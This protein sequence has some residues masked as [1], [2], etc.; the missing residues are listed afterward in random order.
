[1]MAGDEY[2]IREQVFDL[3][4][5]GDHSMTNEL[6]K[7]IEVINDQGIIPVLEGVCQEVIP[8]QS[9]YE[10]DVLELDIGICH[11]ENLEDELPDKIRDAF[12]ESLTNIISR[13][14]QDDGFGASEGNIFPVNRHSELLFQFLEN[15]RFPWWYKDEGIDIDWRNVIVLAR[16]EDET[17]LIERV[18]SL[19]GKKIV[20]NR[21]IWQLPGEAVFELMT[22]LKMDV[23]TVRIIA[24]LLDSFEKMEFTAGLKNRFWDEILKW[25][26]ESR[27]YDILESSILPQLA[28]KVNISPLILAKKLLKISKKVTHQRSSDTHEFKGWLKAEI[29]NLDTQGK[30]ERRIRKKLKKVIRSLEAVSLDHDKLT[31]P[32]FDANISEYL[33]NQMLRFRIFSSLDDKSIE[34]ILGSFSREVTHLPALLKWFST[35]WSTLVKDHKASFHTFRTFLLEEFWGNRSFMEREELTTTNRR[36]ARAILTFFSTQS[37]PIKALAIATRQSIEKGP[38]SKGIGVL[39]ALNNLLD[40][41]ISDQSSGSKPVIASWKDLISKLQNGD[42]HDLP[43]WSL[44]HQIQDP[45]V[46]DLASIGEIPRPQGSEPYDQLGVLLREQLKSKAALRSVVSNLPDPVLHSLVR[47]ISPAIKPKDADQWI[48]FSG[49]FHLHETQ[50]IPGYKLRNDYWFHLFSIL[51]NQPEIQADELHGILLKRLSDF[52]GLKAEVIYSEI[53]ALARKADLDHLDIVKWVKAHVPSRTQLETDNTRKWI[54]KLLRPFGKESMYKESGSAPEQTDASPNKDLPPGHGETQET[55][56]Q[57]TGNEDQKERGI[58]SYYNGPIKEDQKIVENE[59]LVE[60]ESKMTQESS[61]LDKEDA[62]D[63]DSQQMLEESSSMDIS[64]ALLSHIDEEEWIPDVEIFIQNAGMVIIGPFLPN[65]FKT[66]GLLDEHQNFVSETSIYQAIHLLQGTVTR[67]FNSPEHLLTLNKIICGLDPLLP[68]PRSVD[69][70]DAMIR[71]T[72]E[73]LKAV[74]HHWTAL[75][76]T[77]VDGLRDAFFQREGRLLRTEDQWIVQVERRSYDMLLEQIPWNIYEIRLPWLKQS[78]LVE[79]H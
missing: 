71:E 35:R 74:I 75:K 25:A 6:Q 9:N 64:S 59:A 12:R 56:A 31:K 66:L 14:G 27:K 69:I 33:G 58:H 29:K 48:V 44:I 38:H 62:K 32:D 8:A 37:I 36:M 79:W 42:V 68:V 49:A 23:K 26:H 34:E 78:I 10:I 70:S 60:S 3:D 73:L 77:S 53:V 24:D 65:F 22:I 13:S 47:I 2:I 18:H 51:L 50:L 52:T 63:F 61:T 19:I 20:R 4:V 11:L 40:P 5:K 45:N 1:M 57:D 16:E 7:T 41:I 46:P 76:N 43:N 72:D 39:K 55:R 17:E 54:P 30:N 28:A 67:N 21:I 15:G